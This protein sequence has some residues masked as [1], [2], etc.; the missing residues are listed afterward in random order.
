MKICI[1]TDILNNFIWTGINYYIY[2]LL[3]N[4][5]KIDEE[6]EYKFFYLQGI[7]DKYPQYFLDN[8]N[9]EHIVFR[10]PQLLRKI[11]MYSSIYFNLPTIENFVKDIDVYHSVNNFSFPCKDSKLIFTVYDLTPILFPK[12]HKDNVVK[13]SKHFNKFFH[14]SNKIISISESTKNDLINYLNIPEDKIKVIYLAAEEGF[15]Q[16]KDKEKIKPV[17]DYYGITKPYILYVGTLEPR[18]NIENLLRA[19]FKLSKNIKDEYLLVLAGTK[20][21]KYEPIFKLIKEL[22]LESNIIITDYVKHNDLPLLIN[23]ASLFVYISFYEGFGLPVLEAMACG[24]PVITSNTSSLP[25]ITGDAGILV[26]P[27]NVEEISFSIQ[28][29][30]ENS[31]IQKELS[32]KGIKQSKKFSWE[33]TALLTLETYKSLY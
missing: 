4:L 25:E 16:I 9:V 32:I 29:V 31:Y 26:D 3:K 18:K 12:Y 20:G 8:K 13:L 2:Y 19:Y 11:F 5:L 7:K 17:L 14:S 28:N 1:T 21:W 6:N 10:Y 23:G 30:L 22:T 27:K 24:I 15:Y 33:K